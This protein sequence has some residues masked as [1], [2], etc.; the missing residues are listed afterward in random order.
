MKKSTVEELPFW[1]KKLNWIPVVAL[2][3]EER[4]NFYRIEDLRMTE[5]HRVVDE[6]SAR[7]DNMLEL[8]YAW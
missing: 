7:I 4:V 2:D 8:V 5:K 1:A 6:G 3:S